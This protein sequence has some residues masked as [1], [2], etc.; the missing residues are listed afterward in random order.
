MWFLQLLWQKMTQRRRLLEETS[1]KEEAQGQNYGFCQVK[2]H[3]FDDRVSLTGFQ[4]Q[5]KRIIF[6]H[7]NRTFMKQKITQM[8]FLPIEDAE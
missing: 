7:Q 3:C 1:R 2:H 6:C 5:E 4:S 8:E